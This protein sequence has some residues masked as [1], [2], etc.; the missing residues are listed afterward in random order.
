ME[1]VDRAGKE[2]RNRFRSQ[3]LENEKV[4][5]LGKHTDVFQ[6]F[7]IRLP[8]DFLVI[9]S[10]RTNSRSSNRAHEVQLVTLLH[11]REHK[12]RNQDENVG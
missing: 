8:S 2:P 11:K 12:I 3:Y 10:I 6:A 9:N 5:S 4:S 7:V 1:H